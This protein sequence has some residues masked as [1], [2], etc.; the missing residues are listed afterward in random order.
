MD[1]LTHNN[2][3]ICEMTVLLKT[4]FIDSHRYLKFK[5]NFKRTKIKKTQ[6]FTDE[7]KWKHNHHK[8]GGGKAICNESQTLLIVKS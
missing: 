8:G 1:N 3:T 2:F 6:I 5:F 4:E 7:Y